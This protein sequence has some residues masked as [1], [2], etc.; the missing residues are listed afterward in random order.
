MSGFLRISYAYSDMTFCCSVVGHGL[1]ESYLDISQYLA[2]STTQ[3]DRH[4]SLRTGEQLFA[5][6]RKTNTVHKNSKY[7]EHDNFQV[8]R[9]RALFPVPFSS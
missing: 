1:A 7:K 5:E 2:T 4:H 3:Q 9:L 8:L 6:Y